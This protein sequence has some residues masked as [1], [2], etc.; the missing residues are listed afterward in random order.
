[1]AS[2][3]AQADGK[4]EYYGA[5]GSPATFRSRD[6]RANFVDFLVLN[7]RFMMPEHSNIYVGQTFRAW[8][9]FGVLL[10]GLNDGVGTP[11]DQKLVGKMLCRRTR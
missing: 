1:M 5:S 8:T 4:V 2:L 11:R 3:V 6:L 9:R 10:E 7:S